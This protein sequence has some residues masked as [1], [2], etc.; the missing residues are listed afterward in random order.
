MA[1]DKA[2][3]EPAQYKQP[4]RKGK[5]AWRKN[6]DVSDVQAGLDDAREDE[7][8]GGPLAERSSDSLFTFDTT[9]S[10]AIRASV[11]QF[12]KPLK[13]DQILA[14]R[15]AVPSVSNYKRPAGVTDGVIEPKTKRHK[16]ETISRSEYERLQ[17]V[18]YGKQSVN[19]VIQKDDH[20]PTDDPWAQVPIDES[21]ISRYS[22]L[23]RP[24]PPK[25]PVT[26]K[27]NPKSLLLNGTASNARTAPNPGTSYN[28]MFQDW[29]KLITS[30]GIKEIEAERNRLHGNQ[31][32]QDLKE[33]LAIAEK[34]AEQET[35]WQSEAES[36]WEGFE[37]DFD[38]P[39]WLIR[40]K[41][42][43]K[44]PQERRKA[45]R[46]KEREREEKRQK[47]EKDKVAA[48]KR[49][50]QIKAEVEAREKEKSSLVKMSPGEEG[51]QDSTWLRCTAP[52]KKMVPEQSLEVVLPD[53]LEDS[54]RRLKPEGNLLRDRYRNVL[55][56]GKVEARKP[57][58]QA[59][60]PKMEWTEKWVHK[61]FKVPIST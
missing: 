7:I 31:L 12:Y 33:R 34:E 15:S 17:R 30:E 6:V 23:E 20:A 57:T 19:N 37:S 42:E 45:A 8:R 29:D 40:R 32:E 35:A 10:P 3:K 39:E 51:E 38:K 52:R 43:R 44:T 13:S 28:P 53:E 60:K 50:T 14:Q 1:T 56:S 61:D 58:R 49:I 24:Q 26:L 36:V 27:E 21:R 54:L 2:I 59:K 5:K 25:A 18:A 46:K 22:F 4:S 9:G 16:S 55:L 47:K 11:R 48:E 41:L